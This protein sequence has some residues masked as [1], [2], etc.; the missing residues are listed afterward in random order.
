MMEEIL[1]LFQT[2][3]CFPSRY[4][5]YQEIWERVKRKDNEMPNMLQ[6]YENDALGITRNNPDD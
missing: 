2:A 3:V 5:G 4:L 1:C 6:R